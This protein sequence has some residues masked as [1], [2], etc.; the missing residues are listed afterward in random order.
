MRCSHAQAGSA[1]PRYVRVLNGEPSR[2]RTGL[3]INHARQAPAPVAAFRQRHERAF[4]A[5][6][7]AAE[8]RDRCEL[9]P[10]APA[11]WPNSGA[12]CCEFLNGSSLGDLLPRHPMM[13]YAPGQ[14]MGWMARTDPPGHEFGATPAILPGVSRSSVVIATETDLLLSIRGLAGSVLQGARVIS[15][16]ARALPA[17]SAG[18]V[19]PPAIV[20]GLYPTGTR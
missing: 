3:L 13:R 16:L 10:A 11:R 12:K 20:G 6:E 7:P 4:T 9:A 5:R 15:T 19:T 14:A 8:S 2:T 1:T 17:S 18:S